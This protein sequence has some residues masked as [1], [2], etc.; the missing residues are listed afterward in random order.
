MSVQPA[1][2]ARPN[3]ELLPLGVAPRLASWNRTGDPDRVRLEAFLTHAV[4]VLTPALSDVA[5]PLALRLDVGLPAKTPLL[6]A[7]DLDNYVFPLAMRLINVSQRQVACVWATKRHATTSL[8]GIE[9]AVLLADADPAGGWLFVH[10]TASGESGVYKQQIQDALLTV[11]ELPPGP[12]SLELSFTVG[13]RRNWPNLWKATIDA[14]SP[15]LGQAGSAKPWT[16]NDGRIV[17]LGLHRQV[18]QGRGH[19][20]LLAIAARPHE[21]VDP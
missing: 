2:F 7:N 17:E 5:D 4:D 3:G 16:P 12:V 15:L 10:T 20:V 21:G 11:A 6:D 18:E 9:Q 8:I 14:L 13:P 1:F 19:D